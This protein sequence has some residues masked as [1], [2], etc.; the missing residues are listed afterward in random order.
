M[1]QVIN[2]ALLKVAYLFIQ[3]KVQQHLAWKW[4]CYSV[5]SNSLWPQDCMDCS[6]PGSSVPGILLARTLE[7]APF[8]SACISVYPIWGAETSCL[9]S[10]LFSF[11]PLTCETRE[12]DISML[13]DSRLTWLLVSK[14]YSLLTLISLQYHQYHYLGQFES[15]LG[16]VSDWACTRTHILSLILSTYELNVWLLGYASK[17][18]EDEYR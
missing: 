9:P 18:K 8:P 5:V 1:E 15:L 10:P 12:A 2:L 7:W 3:F 17:Y 4:K 11:W 16:Q 13:E 14:Q 6:L